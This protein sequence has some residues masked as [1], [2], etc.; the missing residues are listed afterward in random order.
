M[1]CFD[2]TVES[3]YASREHNFWIREFK[4]FI[5]TTDLSSLKNNNNYVISF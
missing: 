2:F 3:V 5:Y 1:P 4:T